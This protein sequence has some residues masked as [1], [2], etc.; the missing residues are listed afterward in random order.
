MPI[1]INLL[2]EALAAA[3]LR[4]KNPVKRGIW[5][6]SFLVC[7]IVLWIINLQLNILFEKKNYNNIGVN[8]TN[9]MAKFSAVTNEEVKIRD[10]DFKLKQLDQLRTNR[11]LWAPV[12][13]ALQQ[14]MVDE[15][16]VT[17]VKG[18][19]TVS[20]ESA[21]DAGSGTNL[22]HLRAAMVEKI[23]LN[24]S[25]IDMKPDD[26]NYTK[27][28][29]YQDQLKSKVDPFQLRDT[30]WK[31]E[32]EKLAKE[33]QLPTTS[34]P[35]REEIEKKLKELQRL[36]EDNKAEAQKVLV[37]EQEAQLV[38]LYGDIYNVVNRVAVAHSYDLILHYNDVPK[39][40]IWNAQNVARKMQAGALIPMY[41]SGTVDISKYV[42]DTLNAGS[43]T[44]TA[45]TGTNTGARPAGT[46]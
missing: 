14:T 23:S 34:A 35:R 26:E 16:Q 41:M 19:Q 15:I 24:I 44:P 21:H 1:R 33:A 31:T 8:W 39:E 40:E 27:F 9:K 30:T 10:L 45:A 12:L 11:F 2:A 37:K 6:G 4:R 38:T 20:H 36:I 22:Q 18:E 46:K 32:G 7:V 3:E 13:N 29:S 28:K 25:A 42:L 5:V 17:R 43:T